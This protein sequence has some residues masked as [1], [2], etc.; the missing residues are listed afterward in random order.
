MQRRPGFPFAF[1]C[2]RSG[3]CCARP[4][5]V[6]RVDAEDVRRMAAHLGLS[7][8]G[9]RSRYLAASGDRLAEGLGGRCVFLE[10]GGEASCGIYPARPERC[11]SWPFW[12]ELAASERELAAACRV[13]PGIERDEPS[14][15]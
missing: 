8:A 7:E 13:C 4:E 11:R 9:V 1:A 15:G 3:N 5:G 12:P 14:E 10:D 6:V 2:R